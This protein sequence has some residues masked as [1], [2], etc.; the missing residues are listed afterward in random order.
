MPPDIEAIAEQVFV[1]L[2][3][4]SRRAILATLASDGPA[5][6]TDLADWLVRTLDMPFRDAHHVTGAAVKKAE[7]LGCDLPGLPLAELQAI[8]SRITSEVYD[9]L[10]PQA[11]AASRKSYGGTS[12]EQVRAQIARWKEKFCVRSPKIPS[13]RIIFMQR[14]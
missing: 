2:G 7:A 12:P 3:D 10:T 11:S 1:A 4:P 6:A 8:E 5:T 9:V 13:I 14:Q